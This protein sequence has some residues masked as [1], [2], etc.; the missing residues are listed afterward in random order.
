MR[1][2]RRSRSLLVAARGRLQPRRRR[3]AGALRAPGTPRPE[4]AAPPGRRAARGAHDPGVDRR[5]QRGATTRRRRRSSRAARSWSRAR[6]SGCPTAAR[7]SPSTAAC[8][9]R[10]DVTDV[11]DEGDTVLAAFRLREARAAAATAA[12]ACGSG[13]RTAS[14]RSGASWP[15]R[16]PAEGD[17]A[18]VRLGLDGVAIV[19][20]ATPAETDA[21]RALTMH[22]ITL[23][24]PDRPR[25]FGAGPR[26]ER[27]CWPSPPRPRRAAA[28]WDPGPTTRPW[29]LQLSG[30][31]D[32][33]V[34]APVYDIDGLSTPTPRRCAVLHERGRRVVVLLLGRHLRAVPRR[35]G[36]VPRRAAREAAGGLP[37]RAL[38]RHQAA[39]PAGAPAAAGASTCCRR[40]GFDGVDPGQR[41]TATPTARG[42]ALTALG[43]AALQPLAGRREAHA[44]GTGRRPQE[45][46][47]TGAASGATTSTSPCVEQ[48]FAVPGVPPLLAVP[49]ARASR[50]TRWSTRCR[51][52]AGARHPLRLRFSSVFKRS[53]AGP[54][55]AD[56]PPRSAV[57]WSRSRQPVVAAQL[58]L[59]GA[60]LLV[61]GLRVDRRDLGRPALLVER[62]HRQVGGGGVHDLARS[63][64]SPSPRAR[65]PPSRCA[66]RRSRWRGRSPA[67]RRRR[68]AGRSCGPS[69][70]V[71]TRWPRVADGGDAR[72]PRRTAS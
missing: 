29:Q 44:P 14:S 51:R 65:R 49:H 58:G 63:T 60:A 45:R 32:T 28:R 41:R 15:S 2:G 46:R 22:A 48:C 62:D 71:T 35:C 37:R 50:S 20:A 55:Q 1:R 3:R 9:A 6:S 27:S 16:R 40:K 43:P 34:R 17:I 31:I 4:P 21:P 18:C 61:V 57:I 19:R 67:R 7:P 70:A 64:R 8:P 23:L 11:E 72:P 52:G 54:V 13:S 59:A 12:P 36:P 66:R 69:P 47:R 38:A 24:T 39:R 25:S 68:A 53:G 33:S 26:W 10:R 30:T 42:F 56:L 5:A